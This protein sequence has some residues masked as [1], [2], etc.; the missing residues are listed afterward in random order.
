[1]DNTAL[2]QLGLELPLGAAN[3]GKL[4][5][6][7]VPLASTVVPFD[8]KK[9]YETPVLAPILVRATFTEVIVKL[10]P[11]SIGSF[12]LIRVAPLKGTDSAPL[13]PLTGSVHGEP[14]Q[15][16]AVPFEFVSTWNVMLGEFPVVTPDV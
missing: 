2:P 3:D 6:E 15:K 12:C 1:V 14:N 11:D 16:S 8:A 7:I 5:S 9:R 4:D 10:S 13:L